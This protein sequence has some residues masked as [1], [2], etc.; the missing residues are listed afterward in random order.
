MRMAY[1]ESWYKGTNHSSNS[2]REPTLPSVQT[3]NI[4]ARRFMVQISSQA[5][6]KT[7]WKK[8][9]FQWAKFS[10]DMILSAFIQPQGLDLPS[11][12]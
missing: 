10:T 8:D 9:T 1:H 6:E 11:S 12:G 2:E 7:S 4:T 5:S 3:N